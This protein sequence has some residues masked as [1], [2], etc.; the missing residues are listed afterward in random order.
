MFEETVKLLANWKE[1]GIPQRLISINASALHAQN[2]DTVHRYTTIL[3]NTVWT[4]L[5]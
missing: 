4:R 5:L 2:S 1:Q 3:E